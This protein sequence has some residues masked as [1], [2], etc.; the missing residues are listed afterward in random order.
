MEEVLDRA[1]ALDPPRLLPHALDVLLA[2][3]D[4]TQE[5]HTLLGVHAYLALRD[6]G[7]AE[8][9]ALDPLR[10]CEVVGRLLGPPASVDATPGDPDRMRLGT[11]GAHD[12]AALSTAQPRACTVAGYV[13]SAAAGLRI[14]EVL[15][16]RA[17]SQTAR[18]DG[19]DRE[20]RTR[21]AAP[22]ALEN[23]ARSSARGEGARAPSADKHGVP[24]SVGEDATPPA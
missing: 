1:H 2:L 22:A 8:Q 20:R 15:E 5:H 13:A 4:A 19:Q 23:Q 24:P 10:Q 6:I 16:Q 14:E 9:L 12:G 7:A 11:P 21:S 3:H 18:R 17:D